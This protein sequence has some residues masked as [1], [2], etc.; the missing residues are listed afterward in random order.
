MS[1]PTQLGDRRR[2]RRRDTVS[3][4]IDTWLVFERLAHEEAELTLDDL[5]A[6]HRDVGRTRDIAADLNRQSTARLAELKQD[7]DEL[8]RL[9]ATSESIVASAR[10]QTVAALSSADSERIQ[11]I[12]DLD[13]A[14]RDIATADT[15][16]RAATSELRFASAAHQTS[17]I[18][19]ER[20]KGATSRLR[21]ERPDLV[22]VRLD[23]LRAAYNQA[24]HEQAAAHERRA[25]RHQRLTEVQASI[26]TSISALETLAD[27]SRQLDTAQGLF[28]SAQEALAAV[29]IELGEATDLVNA[30]EDQT[31]QLS[32][33]TTQF[34][35][36]LD[37]S[38]RALEQLSVN[39]ADGRGRL[40]SSLGL[41]EQQREQTLDG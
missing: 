5:R 33:A 7:L 12:D 23:S 8:G 19:S 32:V 21:T 26:L 41:P 15:Q 9:I 27:S 34:E 10:R 17:G 6:R 3:S 14:Q 35:D 16:L 25:Q 37:Q 36:S 39:I 18:R 22:Q 11:L 30:V 28:M 1:V 29:T 24:L 2:A 20:L 31:S 13:A 38:L 40:N 4:A